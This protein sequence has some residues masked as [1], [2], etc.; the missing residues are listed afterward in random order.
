MVW[1]LPYE[2]TFRSMN[3]HGWPQLVLYCI[4]KNSDGVEYV[5][6]YGC[7]HIPI[8]PGH[9]TK[10]VRMFSLVED[11]GILSDLLGI[12]QLTD[13]LSTTISNPKAI[14]NPDGR[15]YTK[16]MATGR[17]TVEMNVIQ[18]NMGRHGFVVG[19]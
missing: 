15:Q 5:K 2:I 9:H 3:P 8:A 18:R 7:V 14:A 13:G 6:A 19:Q 16:V 1:N 10:V 11:G 17:V 12:P 4:N